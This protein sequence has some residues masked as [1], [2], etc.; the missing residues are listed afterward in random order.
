MQG[1]TGSGQIHQEDC[2]GGDRGGSAGLASAGSRLHEIRSQWKQ[3]EN[4]ATGED[5]LP[6]ALDKLFGE[7]GRVCGP[8]LF[9]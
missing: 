6:P 5:A 1:Q 7:L 8:V 9:R 4:K 3:S 2:A